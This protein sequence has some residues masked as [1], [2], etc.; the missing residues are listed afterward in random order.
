MSAMERWSDSMDVIKSI[1]ALSCHLLWRCFRG[2]GFSFSDGFLSRRRGF[3]FFVSFRSHALKPIHTASSIHEMLLSGVK[4]MALR[5][6]FHMDF[7]CGR[8]GDK[9]VTASAGNRHLLIGR[10]NVFFHWE[11][12]KSLNSV[13]RH[14][15]RTADLLQ[16]L[17]F[18]RLWVMMFSEP[19]RA[20]TAKKKKFYPSTSL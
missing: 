7:L 20:E 4:R 16:G 14:S 8:S 17:A 19:L 12:R 3:V 18:L 11:M 6:N 13:R 1:N 10:M 15:T 5:T 2:R 9:C